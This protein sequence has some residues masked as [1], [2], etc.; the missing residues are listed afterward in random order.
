MPSLYL[1]TTIPSYLAAFPSRDLI[2][3]AHQQ[4]THEW[5]RTAS[6]RFDLYIS[7]AVLDEIHAGD[8]DAADRRKQLVDGLPILEL[9][10]DVAALV[11][12]YDDRLGLLGRARA[13]LLHIAFAV[14]YEM[15]YLVTWNC[16]HIANGETIRRLVD[17]NT[18]LGRFTPVIVTPEELLES[19]EEDDHG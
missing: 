7:E 17:A 18:E 16:R 2:I 5:W 1:E 14:A 19:T 3:A 12:S 9:S 4:M 13:D 11:D 6:D 10:D 15:D 8:R